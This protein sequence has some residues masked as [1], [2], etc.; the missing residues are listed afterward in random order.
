MTSRELNVFVN[1]PFDDDYKPCFEALVFAITA[2]GYRVRCALEENDAGQVRY[3]KLC[4]LIGECNRSVHDLS[5]VEL[6]TSGLP[7][8]NM[9]FELGL[10]QGARRFGSK[11]HRAKTA[12]ILVRDRFKLPVYMSDVAGNDPEPHH[13]EPDEVIRAVRRYLHTRPDGSQLPGAAFMV[14]TFL[15][16]QSALP[17]LAAALH[18]RPDELDCLRDYKDYVALLAEFLRQD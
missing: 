3:D 12:L 14:S 2:S 5:R 18:I 4:R 17:R 15:R 16:F 6:T 1:C 13:G 8:F 7:R 9:P 11:R 10:F